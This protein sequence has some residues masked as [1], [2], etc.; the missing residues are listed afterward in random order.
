MIHSRVIHIFFFI[1]T[2]LNLKNEIDFGHVSSRT[3]SKDP[4]VVEPEISPF[5]NDECS[6]QVTFPTHSQRRRHSLNNPSVFHGRGWNT[7]YPS[8][9]H[10]IVP[11]SE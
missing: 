7:I 10:G 4:A 9:A 5:G 6:H 1:V 11:N 3:V 2:V 8:V